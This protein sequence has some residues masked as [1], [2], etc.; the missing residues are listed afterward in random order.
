MAAF[1]RDHEAMAES[2]YA[3]G[4]P[5]RQIDMRA[6]RAE[7]QVLSDRYLHRPLKE[8]DLAGLVADLVQGA[9]RFGLEVPPDFLL[10]GKALMTI[11]GMAKE[12]DPDF[13]VMAEA[14]PH[15]VALLRR[16]YSPD[17]VAADLWRAA[18]RL[19]GAAV[20]LPRQLHDVLDELHA[21]RL[22]VRAVDP[23]R[24]PALDRL[25]RRVGSALLAASCIATGT[26]VLVSAPDQ[27]TLGIVLLTLAGLLVVGQIVADLTRR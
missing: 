6:F 20:D 15:F 1:R 27:Q 25:G 5:T 13:D 26:W 12:I 9:G 22:T 2:L 21:G 23:D 10:V 24:G 4:T 18:Q 3:I 14:R 11:E 17:R 16:R 7:V 19:S 8:L